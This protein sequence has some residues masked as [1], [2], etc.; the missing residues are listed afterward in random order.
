M[1]T[2]IWEDNWLPSQNGLKLWSKKPPD[3]SLHLVNDLIN[4]ETNSW[5]T[6]IIDA[7]FMPFEAS[8]IKHI[9]LI[10]INNRDEITWHGTADVFYSVKSG[11]QAIIEWQDQKELKPNGNCSSTNNTI[12]KTFGIYPFPPNTVTYFGVLPT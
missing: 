7:L 5:K 10:N 4:M 2:K 11:Y 6:N 1:H 12:W 9:P 8:Q 3:C